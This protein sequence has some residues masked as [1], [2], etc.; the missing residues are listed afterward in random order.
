MVG[1]SVGGG[2]RQ[3]C[4]GVEVLKC[5]GLELAGLVRLLG[6]VRLRF[7]GL[8]CWGVGVLRCWSW[9]WNLPGW[10]FLGVCGTCF[11]ARVLKLLLRGGC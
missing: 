8:T 5:W 4:W 2:V 1:A 11:G 6:F 10:C 7:R 9:S 3:M